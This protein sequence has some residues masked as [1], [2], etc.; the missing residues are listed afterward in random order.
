MVHFH[1]FSVIKQSD[2]KQLK[3][4]FIWFNI[5]GCSPSV[6]GCEVQAVD[7]ITPDVKRR[8]K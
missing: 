1:F 6:K 5:P 3:R 7:C 8:E 2:K 4:E